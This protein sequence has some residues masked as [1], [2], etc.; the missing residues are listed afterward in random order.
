MSVRYLSTA[1]NCLAQES[2]LNFKTMELPKL[3][4]SNYH[5]QVHHKGRHFTA[6]AVRKAGY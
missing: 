1:Y 2:C 3:P 4:I 5:E 6:G